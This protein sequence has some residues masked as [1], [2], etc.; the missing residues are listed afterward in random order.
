MLGWGT[1]ACSAD[2]DAARCFGLRC[3]ADNPP[4][5]AEWFLFV[6]DAGLVDA[7]L[8]VNLS[9][10]GRID[11]TFSMSPVTLGGYLQHVTPLDLPGHSDFLDALQAGQRLRVTAGD[12]PA[13]SLALAGSRAELTRALAVCAPSGRS[14]RPAAPSCDAEYRARVREAE[15]LDTV[16]NG[17]LA[18]EGMRLDAEARL[19]LCRAGVRP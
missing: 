18:A 1:A 9:V 4:P 16:P 17:R 7:P 11:A 19:N 8:Q 15:R 2:G 14:D 6:D 3:K 10:E 13:F 5:G 12:L